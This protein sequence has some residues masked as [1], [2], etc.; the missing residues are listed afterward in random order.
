MF[1]HVVGKE[2]TLTVSTTEGNVQSK[3]NAMEV[4]YAVSMC[5]ERGAGS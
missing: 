2:E 4:H 5:V 1:C 3:S